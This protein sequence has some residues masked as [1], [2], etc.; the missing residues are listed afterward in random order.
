[1]G[2]FFVVG[3]PVQPDRQCYLERAADGELIRALAEG[4]FCYVLAPQAL[5]KTSLMGHAVRIL[6]EQGQAAALVDLTQ[7]GARE[8][9]SDPARWF[10]S[11]AYRIVRE[12]RLKLELQSWWQENSILAPE[13]RLA[14]FF[15]DIVL[16]NTRTPVT[17]FFDELERTLELPFAKDFFGE[18]RASYNA[19]TT[20]PEFDRLNFVLL[21]ASSPARLCPDPDLSPFGMGRAIELNDFGFPETLGLAPGFGIDIEHATGLLKRVHHWTQ[22]QPY[23]TQKLARAVARRAGGQ[24]GASDV[25]QLVQERFLNPAAAKDEPH[26]NSIRARL[27]QAK[28]SRQSLSTLGSGR[29]RR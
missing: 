10:Y 7:V 6:R 15:R 4:E 17:I 16:G 24:V 28:R 27:T 23:L 9:S 13:Q 26:F 29:Q 8:P 11:I 18:I 2:E 5:G 14:E 20:E 12:L 21:G 1:M 25:D 3:G 22:G 19:R